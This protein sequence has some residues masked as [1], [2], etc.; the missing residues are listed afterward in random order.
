M[1]SDISRLDAEAVENVAVIFRTLETLLT[2]YDPSALPQEGNY[3]LQLDNYNFHK[4]FN[5][6]C[7]CLYVHT[8]R[9]MHVL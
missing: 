5:Y 7:T 4:Y 8:C 2:K 6:S 3:H 9:Y 1:Y